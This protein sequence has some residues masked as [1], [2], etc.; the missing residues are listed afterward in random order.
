MVQGKRKIGMYCSPGKH[1]LL[2]R[3]AWWRKGEDCEVVAAYGIDPVPFMVAAQSYGNEVSE[4]D[5]IGGISGQPMALTKGVTTSLPI[6]ARAEIV[7]E[8]IVARDDEMPEGPLENLLA[9]MVDPNH[10]SR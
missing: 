4:L 1:G 2:D 6:P 3:E 9:I 10:H 5:I 8:G 7:I